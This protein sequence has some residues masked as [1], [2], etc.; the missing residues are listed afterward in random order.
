[1]I[2]EVSKDDWTYAQLWGCATVGEWVEQHNPFIQKRH[3]SMV[4]G[5]ALDEGIIGLKVVEGSFHR[6][7][8]ME[9]SV[10]MW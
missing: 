5:M 7:S 6:K 8:F 3:L 4:A 2:D 1:M 9:S 10:M